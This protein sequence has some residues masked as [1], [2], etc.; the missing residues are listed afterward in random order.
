MELGL[1]FV[2]FSVDDTIYGPQRFTEVTLYGFCFTDANKREFSIDNGELF[3]LSDTKCRFQ[4][5]MFSCT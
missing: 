2:S 1:D 3:S 4:L 5:P